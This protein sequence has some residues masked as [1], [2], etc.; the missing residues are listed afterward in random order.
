MVNRCCLCCC[1]GE[2]VDHLLLH[3]KFAHALWSEIY[4]VFGI[5]KTVNSLLLVWRNWFGKHMS[6]TWNMV[7]PCL[8]CLVWQEQNTHT[9]E[10]IERP[11]DLLKSLLFGTLF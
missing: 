5:P 8:M 4:A 10:D 3:C 1:D 2:F 11:L 6:T 9:F 7:L